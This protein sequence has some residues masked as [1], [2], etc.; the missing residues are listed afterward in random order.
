[1]AKKISDIDQVI[2]K[3]P[4]DK[5]VKISD[6]AEINQIIEVLD[7]VLEDEANNLTEAEKTRLNAFKIAM[8]AKLERVTCEESKEEQVSAAKPLEVTYGEGTITVTIEAKDENGN[9][10]GDVDSAEATEPETEST[11]TIN[12]DRKSNGTQ[13]YWWIILVCVVVLGAVF[14]VI[15]RKRTSDNRE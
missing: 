10:T 8:E 5:D 13:W 11:D 12:E 2:A 7:S 9:D 1:M 15:S 3:L 6:K 14:I 4:A